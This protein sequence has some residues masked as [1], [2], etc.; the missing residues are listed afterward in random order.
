MIYIFE[1]DVSNSKS[2]QFALQKVYGLNNYQ[3]TL[4]C[5][6]LGF[7]K[8]L[9]FESLSDDQ[10]LKLIKLIEK[11]GLKITSELKKFQVFNLKSL[12]NIKCYRGLRR[13]N[14]LPVRGQRT[15]TNAKSAKRFFKY[16]I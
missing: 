12:I 8:N 9:K 10:I 7:T 2:I 5:K 14:G 15:H 1:T 13:L 11:S 16:Y 4:I 3:I 6:K